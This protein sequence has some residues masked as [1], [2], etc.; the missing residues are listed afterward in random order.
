MP[1]I[2]TTPKTMTDGTVITSY[3][4][5]VHVNPETFSFP[6]PQEWVI[7]YNKGT[8]DIV[9]TIGEDSGVLSPS[10]SVEVKG[11]ITTLILS[12]VRGTQHFEIRSDEEG[13]LLANPDNVND[14]RKEINEA[15]SPHSTLKSKLDS[16][17]GGSSVSGDPNVVLV[18]DFSGAGEHQKIQA[19]IDFASS[20]NK[21]TVLLADKDY[22]LT[23]SII[24]KKNVLL[25]GGYGTG[26]TIGTNVRGIAIEQNASLENV[27]IGID[28]TGYNKEAIY[29]DGAQKFYNTW[30]RS[31]L[32][33]ITLVNWTGEQTGTGIHCFSGGN[34]H[35]ISFVL[36]DSIKI[37]GFAKGIHLKAVKPITGRSWVN[38]NTFDKIAIEDCVDMIVIEGSET[39][40]FECSGNIFTNLQIQPSWV[41]ERILTIQGQY[42]KVEGICWDLH[43]I[44]HT[45]P[46][47]EFKVESDYNELE[48]KSIPAARILNN[49]KTRNIFSAYN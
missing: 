35:E 15:K 44:G 39:V 30:N 48:M 43:E 42:N 33:D 32:R 19:A 47:V 4:N 26:L 7:L 38:A 3:A 46:V 5:T 21:R 27:K 22:Y 2:K 10:R 28:Y 6:I 17:V 37:V 49:G 16:M 13:T 31:R 29:L 1:I 18:E 12:S 40:P 11:I 36:F 24:V 8:E 34:E 41:T 25:K 20:N 45:G 14:I 9:Y 23:G